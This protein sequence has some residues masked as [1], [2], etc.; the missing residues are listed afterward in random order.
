M[1]TRQIRKDEL[2]RRKVDRRS[3]SRKRVDRRQAGVASKDQIQQE[4]IN[5]PRPNLCFLLLYLDMRVCHRI[6]Q[7]PF[8]S[9][10]SEHSHDGFT[11]RQYPAL[12]RRIF[13]SGKPETQA[14][15]TARAM[16]GTQEMR[17]YE[18]HPHTLR[19]YTKKANADSNK[20][21]RKN[22]LPRG[23]RLQRL[24]K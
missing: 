5:K 19:R 7:R 13:G 11:G 2:K 24:I 17:G 4:F 14:L 8:Q 9:N 18:A 10:L 21:T 1:Y 6:T 12:V 3:R 22:V 16:S 20:A 15:I 23:H